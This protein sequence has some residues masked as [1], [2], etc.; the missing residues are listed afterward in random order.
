MMGV[1]V[2]KQVAEEDLPAGEVTVRMEFDA[3]EVKPGDRW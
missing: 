3:D 2:F 1:F